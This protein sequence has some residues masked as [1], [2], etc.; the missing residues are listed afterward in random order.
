MTYKTRKLFNASTNKRELWESICIVNGE[1]HCQ[2]N[3]SY[4]PWTIGDD[5]EYGSGA[6]YITADESKAISDWLLSEGGELGENVL[7]WISW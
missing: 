3:D 2:T 6:G 7:I 4:M 1:L 5:G